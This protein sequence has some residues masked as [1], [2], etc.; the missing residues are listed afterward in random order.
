MDERV[1]KRIADQLKPDKTALLVV[2]VQNDFCHSEGVFGKRDF[3]LSHVEQS[4]NNLLPFIDRCRQ[5]GL[6]TIFVRT[7]HSNWTDSDSWISRLEGAGKE[8][9]ICRPDTWGAEFYKVAPQASDF[10]VTKHR[11]S[12][13]VG[14]DLNLVLRA[15]GIE[16]LLMTGVA[17]NVCVET[18][19][20]DGFNLDFR[21]ILVEDCC[22]AFS[23]EEHAATITNINK[24]FGIV[25]DS[26]SLVEI[27]GDPGI[28]S[29]SSISG[30]LGREKS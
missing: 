15:R 30:I 11:F 16:T 21:I 3:N 8:M 9:L 13:F 26:K 24:Y 18:T 14:T 23:S 22:G 4:V 5:F 19:A 1:K 17:T 28:V 20:R 29:P 12:G 27:M 10:I 2:D 25:A 7:I 6:R